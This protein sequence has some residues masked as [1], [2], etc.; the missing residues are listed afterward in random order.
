MK[1]SD[2]LIILKSV[3]VNNAHGH[4]DISI[5]M[6]KLSHKSILEPLKLLFENCLWTGIFPDRWKKAN[7]FQFTK[8][9]DKQLLKNYRPVSLLPIWGK[10]FERIIFNDLFKYFKE[11]HLISPYQSGFNPGDS[12]VQKFI[13]ITH[14]KLWLQP[15]SWSARC[16][17]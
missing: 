12:C 1:E 16:V 17:S 5:R 2:I 4:N 3:D 9:D 8:K 14:E 6:L 7:I 15:V 13:A 10:I 11:N